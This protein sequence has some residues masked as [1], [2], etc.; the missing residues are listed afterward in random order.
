MTDN[1]KANIPT[2]EL[3]L[4][5]GETVAMY[6]YLT[7]GEYREIQKIMLKGGKF[8]SQTEKL[9]SLSAEVYMEAQDK[10]V[11]FMVKSVTGTDKVSVKEFSFDWFNSLKVADGNKVYDFV[12]NSIKDAQ[13]PA[14]AKKN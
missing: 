6:E 7:T 9:E 3:K 13:L 4:D 14:E 10:G 2:Q 1:I 8:N 5:S 12:N 11:S